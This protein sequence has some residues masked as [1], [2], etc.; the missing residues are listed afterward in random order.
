[1]TDPEFAPRYPVVTGADFTTASFGQTPSQTVGPYVHIGLLW[2]DGE[3]VVPPGTDGAVTVTFTVIDGS[4]T[5]MSDAMIETWQADADGRFDHPDDPRGAVAPRTEGFRG[6]GR[7]FADETGT[8][9]ITT[10]KPGPLPAENNAVEAPHIDVGIF[11]RGMLE[12]VVTRVYFPDESEANAVDPVLSAL[13]EH[14]RARLVARSV[15]GGY[16]LD[17]VLQNTDPDGDETPFF[18]L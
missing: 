1:M 7:T 9:S 18:E 12:R 3:D 2:P 4:R 17:I 15:D 8:M 13:P 6:F 11:A 16:H 10:I 5:P 14:K